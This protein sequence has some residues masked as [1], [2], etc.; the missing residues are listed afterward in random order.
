MLWGRGGEGE[1]RNASAL[2]STPGSERRFGGIRRLAVAKSALPGPGGPWW[3]MQGGHAPLP[4]GGLA[5][6]RCLKE[7]VSKLGQRVVCPLTNPRG[8]QSE[9]CLSRES[10]PRVPQRGRPLFTKVPHR[11]ASGGKGLPS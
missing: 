6:E 11:S 8:L 2:L 7:R 9:Q 4:A 5:V 3:G 10:S 1:K